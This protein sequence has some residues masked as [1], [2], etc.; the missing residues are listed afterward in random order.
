MV[1]RLI[2]IAVV[3]LVA[4]I[5]SVPA[6]A[7]PGGTASA[8]GPTAVTMA[9]PGG[10]TVHAG[11]ISNAA[12]AS[13]PG[14]Y[15]TLGIPSPSREAGA[16]QPSATRQVV[17]LTSGTNC[18]EAVCGKVY[19]TGLKITSVFTS[20]QGNVGCTNPHYVIVKG[21]DFA[22]GPI[23]RTATGSEVCAGVGEGTYYYTFSNNVPDRMP[24]TCPS[25]SILSVFWD[26]LPGDPMFT[27]HS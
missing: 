13:N 10:G 3:G 4:G 12:L 11:W 2:L 16:T 14:L 22:T 26:F 24:Y 9:L 18:D 19:G 20:A 15:K 27:I 17:P 1:R 6:V 25:T 8:A 21:T 23:L 5:S 7:M